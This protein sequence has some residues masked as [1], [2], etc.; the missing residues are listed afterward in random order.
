M[1]QKN[2]KGF[3]KTKTMCACALLVAATVVIAYMCKLFMT[4]GAVRVTFENLPIIISGVIFGPLVGGIVGVATDLI[5]YLLSAQI[6]PP[7]LIVTL[8]AALIGVTSGLVA[9][10]LV[11]TSGYM[12]II[13]SELLAHTVGSLIVKSIGL[14]QFYGIAVLWRIPLYAVIMCVEIF[15]LCLLYR[16]SGFKN[17]LESHRSLRR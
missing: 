14:Y 12:Q 1:K 7:N 2:L 4:F 13:I 17:L 3:G 10:F 16:N 5:S 11:K 9:K 8:G 15:I 6:Y